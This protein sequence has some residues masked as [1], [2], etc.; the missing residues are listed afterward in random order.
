MRWFTPLIGILLLLS[1][2]AGPSAADDTAEDSPWAK[3]SFNA[4]AFLSSTAT[5]V[6]FGSGLG[7]TINLE[8]AL[9]LEATNRVF[10]LDTYWRFT[11][12]RRHRVDFSWFSLKRS[13][14]RK[15]TD[16]I[17]INPPNDDE[18]TL[19]TGAEVE[20]FIDLDIFEVNYRY[21]FIQD[22]RLD[23]AGGI[24]LYV[25]PISFGL[26]V[27][28]IVDEQG[29]QAFT[30]PLPVLS[31]KID[32]LIAPKWYFRNGAQLFYVE[33]DGMVGS[34]TNL[35]SGLEYNPWK[36]FGLGVGVESM[37]L[38]LEGNGQIVYPDNDLK[39]TVGFNYFGLNLYGRVYF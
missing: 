19:E 7:V 23:M 2:A 20:S 16:D 26:N 34:V 18:I 6:R 9:G 31:L 21:S 37:R 8:D 15:L 14:Y 30:A 25:M 32:V 10:R 5:D 12:N 39:G 1:I 24:G 22:E 3:F 4:G 17:T 33:Y 35:R 13:A 28:G 36:H 11:D 29:D 27:T 38:Y